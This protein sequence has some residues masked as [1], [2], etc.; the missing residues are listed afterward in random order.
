MI[1]FGE[2][3]LYFMIIKLSPTLANEHLHA[4]NDI[5]ANVWPLTVTLNL[6]N[7]TIRVKIELLFE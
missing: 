6:F 1:Q 7:V 2:K 3:Y 5:N 4:Q